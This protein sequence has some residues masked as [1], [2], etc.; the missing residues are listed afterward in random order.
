[1]KIVVFG[2]TGTI[3]KKVI[4]QALEQNHTVTAFCRNAEAFSNFN[5]PNLK[6]MQGDVHNQDQVNSA[7]ENQD[8]VIVVLGSGKSRTST[9]R[10]EGTKR[11]I[12][13]ME[14]QGVSRLICQSTLGVGDSNANLNFFWKY[15][16]F[17]WFLKKIFLDHELQE[18]LVNESNLG[19][20]IVRPS[21]FTDGPKTGNYLH[22][23][24]ASKKGLKLKISRSDVA[25]FLLTQLSS[26]QYLRKAVGVSY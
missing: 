13:A 22:G 2:S 24:S 4:E 19:W 1:M 7:V 6:I 5:S 14:K 21:A 10:S 8:A 3:G 16:M 9:V 12:K 25:H 11:V 18:R 15:I 20:T 17:G 23:F 26:T